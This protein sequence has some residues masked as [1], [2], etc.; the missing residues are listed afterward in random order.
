MKPVVNI[1][2]VDTFPFE[3]GENF[4]V[5]LAP[6]RERVGGEKLGCML[7]I[8]P[9]GKSAFPFHV[10]HTNEEMFFIVE[11]EGTYRYGEERHAIKS[12][13]L[14]G[15]P[16]GGPENAHQITNTGGKPLTYLAFSTM[17]EPEVVE[18]PDSNKFAMY[19]QSQDGSPMTARLRF[20]GRPEDSLDYWDGEI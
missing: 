19:S 1:G 3:Q 10:H 20:V 15:A 8:V 12:G 6:L 17:L 11:G 7:H 9:P 13:D 18:Y 4:S 16:V 5:N 2:E 14:L